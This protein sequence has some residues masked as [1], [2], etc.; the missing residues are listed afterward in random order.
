[1]LYLPI[2]PLFIVAQIQKNIGVI[3]VEFIGRRPY[4]SS[5]G[6][7]GVDCQ[8]R[9]PVKVLRRG[10]VLS[11]LYRECSEIPSRRVIHSVYGDRVCFQAF[12]KNLVDDCPFLA[13]FAALPEKTLLPIFSE[14]PN[15]GSNSL[16]CLSKT[17][18]L[19]AIVTVLSRIHQG[20]RWHLHTGLDDFS[21]RCTKNTRPGHRFP[22]RSER[23]TLP[24]VI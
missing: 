3:Y 17:P 18:V 11:R 2:T 8:H 10:P 5:V 16:M 9:P 7:R 22:P 12:K 23:T 13:R 1:M 14:L 15:S 19:P 21:R 6:C 4:G 20:V 24:R